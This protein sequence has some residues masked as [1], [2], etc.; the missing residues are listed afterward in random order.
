MCFPGGATGKELTCQC[1]RCR[2]CWIR[3]IPLEEEMASHSSSC[4]EN[5]MDRVAW[6][7]TVHGVCK[8]S[9]MTDAT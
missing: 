5:P 8:E 1:R 9:D 3:K 2:R 7:T 4:L 6:W